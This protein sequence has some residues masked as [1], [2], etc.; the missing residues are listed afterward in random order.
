[1]K[2]IIMGIFVFMLGFMS[3]AKETKS[4]ISVAYN[5]GLFTERAENM[6]T[7]LSA[8][9]IDL[10]LSAYFNENWG[11]YLN[12]DYNFVDKATVSSGGISLTTTSSDWDF[13]MVLSAIIGPTYKFNIN[14]S[15]ELF[16]ALG[17][18]FAQYSLSSKY[19]GTLNYSFGIGGD[20][21]IRYLPTKNFYLSVGSLLSHDFY[22]KG[23]VNTAYGTTKVSDSYN[24][25]SFRPYIGIGFSFT[26]IIK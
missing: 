7:Q 20:I 24:F 10:S 21:G 22:C 8:N 5:F 26:E 15:F 14:E 4:Y 25:G 23:E 17:F 19:A 12:T 6:Q 2:K 11:I 16:S 1:M 9:G 13:S 3:F 18:H